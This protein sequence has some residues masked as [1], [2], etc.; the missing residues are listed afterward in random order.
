[1]GNPD[2]RYD[3]LYNQLLL[4][5]VQTVINKSRRATLDD[6][7]AIGVTYRHVSTSGI[8]LGIGLGY[9]KLV[10]DF[11]LPAD[12]NGYFM[13]SIQPFF[14]RDTSQYHMIQIH[15]SFDVKLIN[16]SAI[17]G[18]NCTGISNISFRKHIN[19]FNLSR[20][21]TEYF[22][23]EIYTGIYGEFKRFRLDVG[24]RI[25]HWKHRDDAIANNGLRVDTYNP[26]KW[27]FQLSYD[28]WRSNKME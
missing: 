26:S 7:Y 22:S 9:A 14:W 12:G 17:L 8:N 21:K 19:S 28:F 1:V 13:Q 18:L 6:E 24:Y 3:F 23:S 4:G 20:N 16:K 2:K 25:F 10:Q 27:R 5:P 15:P 11:L